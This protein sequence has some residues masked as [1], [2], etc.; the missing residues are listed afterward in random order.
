[1]FSG[2]AEI[3]LVTKFRF[4]NL[5][6]RRSN[7]GFEILRNIVSQIW[8]SILNIIKGEDSLKQVEDTSKQW[9]SES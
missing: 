2:G 5:S 4:D 1:M 3:Q 6:V 8:D 9:K 7:H